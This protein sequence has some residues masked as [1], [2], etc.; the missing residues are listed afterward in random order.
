MFDYRE[1]N[2]GSSCDQKA[3]VHYTVVLILTYDSNLLELYSVLGL[4]PLF[5]SL[6]YQKGM[7]SEFVSLGTLLVA[8]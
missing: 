4:P 1:G 7:S 5:H 3:T 2:N 6:P 8:R